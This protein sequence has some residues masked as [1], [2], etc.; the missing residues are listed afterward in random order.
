MSS[1]RLSLVLPKARLRTAT[2]W[3]AIAILCLFVARA[4]Q[5]WLALAGCEQT[6][7][8]GAVQLARD[9][10]NY[11][12]GQALYSDFRGPPYY[13]LEYG[14]TVP[15]LMRTLTRASARGTLACLRADRLLTIAT[16]F[17]AFACLLLLARQFASAP[18]A[19]K[20]SDFP[21]GRIFGATI[22][23]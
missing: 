11:T 17:A 5:L 22:A 23:I 8:D 19:A 3:V 6:W 1:T 9:I 13:A 7:D 15:L 14:P 21:P 10:H 4:T 18:A 20:G 2:G 16:S 12:L